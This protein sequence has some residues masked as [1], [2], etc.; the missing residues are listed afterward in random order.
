MGSN[1]ILAARDEAPAQA[2]EPVRPPRRKLP[3]G[4]L[5][6]R[7][8]A[9]AWKAC[10]GASPSRVRTPQPPPRHRVT[11]VAAF[12]EDVLGELVVNMFT[13]LDGVLQ[14]PGAP[15]EDREGEFA[16]GGWQ[17]PYLDEES[18]KVITDNIAGLEALL[19]GRKTYEVFAAYWPQQPAENP[20]AVRLNSAPKYVASRTLGTV[21]WANS[22]LIHGDVAEAVARVKGEFGRLDVIGSGNLVQTLLRNELV[23]RLNLW[24]FPVLLGSG[25]RLFAEGT[26]PTALRL[27]E[28][29]TFP[30]GA[31]Q[32][33]YERAGK[34]TFGSMA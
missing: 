29:V 19:L 28:S 25:K 5:A 14:G 6:E 13:S 2:L 24:V 7:S 20:I 8:K 27:V 30:K 15:D 33:T 18:G 9:H 3:G 16:Y 11:H 10:R 17:A 31:V 1:P 22:K 23:D 21:G 32:L 4:G 34:P 26:V 12:G